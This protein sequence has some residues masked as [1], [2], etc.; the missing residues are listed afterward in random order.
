V[1]PDDP[2]LDLLR[3]RA[4]TATRTYPIGP[5]MGTAKALTTVRS[6]WRQLRPLTEWLA[7]HV[8]PATDPAVPPA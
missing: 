6:G 2:D 8:G 7:D 5:W 4:L 1:D 3:M